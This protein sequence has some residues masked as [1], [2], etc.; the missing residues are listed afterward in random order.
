MTGAKLWKILPNFSLQRSITNEVHFSSCVVLYPLPGVVACQLRAT[1]TKYHN[2]LLLGIVH[3]SWSRDPLIFDTTQERCNMR[4]H[5]AYPSFIWHIYIIQ[6][7]G[8][9]L[10]RDR[11]Y[12]FLSVWEHEIFHTSRLIG[13]SLFCV[14]CWNSFYLLS[15]LTQIMSHYEHF[16]RLKGY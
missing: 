11:S 13:R 5:K 16:H 7:S 1:A 4:V 15:L 6:M 8:C 2:N 12:N 10:F 3:F 9:S 14:V